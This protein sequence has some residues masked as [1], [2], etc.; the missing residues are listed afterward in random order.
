MNERNLDFLDIITLIGFVAQIQNMQQ[1]AEET[2]YIHE[3]IR[4]LAVEVDRLHKEN[5]IIMNKLD[6]ILE[7]MR[8]NGINSETRGR[9]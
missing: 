9:S 1:D 8:N 4:T 2:E 5:E 7:G 6:Q 3:V